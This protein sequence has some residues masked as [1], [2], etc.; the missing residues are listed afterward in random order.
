MTISS[1]EHDSTQLEQAFKTGLKRSD[2]DVYFQQFHQGATLLK[3]NLDRAALLVHSFKQLAVDRTSE[4]KRT[5]KLRE[6]IDDLLSTT[7]L[8]LKKESH[9]LEVDVPDDLELTSFPG[10]LGQVLENLVNNALKHAFLHK[11]HGR[12]ILQAE[13]LNDEDNTVVIMISDNG[14]GIAEEVM[15]KVF[16][17]FFTTARGRGGT[18]LGMHL[19]QQLVSRVLQGTIKLES[20]LGEG[21]T[22]TV[23][24][25][26]MAQA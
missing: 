23:Q 24:L 1:L 16:D 15:N 13:Q 8:K 20:T 5:F 10:A 19:V 7:W 2:V 11:N 21:T 25:P 26:R 18:G 14:E 3:K 6:L 17:P 22:V 9:T 4:E 12:I